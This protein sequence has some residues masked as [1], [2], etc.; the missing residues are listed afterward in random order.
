MNKKQKIEQLQKKLRMKQQEMCC[1]QD[2][3]KELE[4][5]ENE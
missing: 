1:L 4:G 2:E 5:E 3:I